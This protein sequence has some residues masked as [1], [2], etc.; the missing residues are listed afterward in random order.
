MM[1]RHGQP[2]AGIAQTLET[3]DTA[4]ELP[5]TFPLRVAV[6]NVAIVTG[7]PH[8]ATVG[9]LA[10]RA[11]PA[12][13]VPVIVTPS[14]IKIGVVTVVAATVFG[15]V[16]PSAQGTAHVQPTRAET[17]RFA[18]CV[19]EATMNGAVPVVTVEVIWPEN[20]PV[21]AVKPP[22]KFGVP[23]NVGEPVKVPAKLPPPLRMFG[24]LLVKPALKNV[25]P[26]NVD[27]DSQVFVPV[28]TLFDASRERF[29]DVM[30]SSVHKVTALGSVSR[31]LYADEP[32]KTSMRPDESATTGLVFGT[33]P[34]GSL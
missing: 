15:V 2:V 20:V 6:Q 18:T 30:L 22:E 31:N 5:A 34:A 29:D 14:R 23:E 19:V 11:W 8:P 16:E 10:M 3:T 17:F 1:A 24:P 27:V 7:V 25:G 32:R 13:G 4:D 12:V 26:L 33:I 9:L 21:V 28:Q